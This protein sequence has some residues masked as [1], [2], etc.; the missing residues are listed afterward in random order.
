[1]RLPEH[2]LLAD[3]SAPM[4]KQILIY[5][6]ADAL[7][8]GLYERRV[9]MREAARDIGMSTATLSRIVQGK[10]FEM[11]WVIS[12]AKWLHL[13]PQQLWDLLNTEA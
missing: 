11:K 9:S 4:T 1:M 2:H 3:S 8:A 7:R 6:L 13:T 10:G 5:T 12:I